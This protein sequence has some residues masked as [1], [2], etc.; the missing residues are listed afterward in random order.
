[1]KYALFSMTKNQITKSI[2]LSMLIFFFL[3]CDKNEVVVYTSV[4]QIFSEPILKE[5]EKKSGIKILALYDVEASKTVGLVNRLIAEKESPKADVFWNSEVSRTIQLKKQGILQPYKSK[6]WD[7]FPRTFKDNEFYWT[8]F[9]ARS[10]ILL[11]NTNLLT[12]DEVP[13]SIFD[14]IKPEWKGKTT[15][16]YPLFG[17]TSTHIAALYVLFGE[18]KVEQYLKNLVANKVVVVDG[19]SVTRD[20][21]AEGKI[22]IGFTDTDDANVAVQGGKPV[23]V[24]YPDKEDFGTLLIPNTVALVKNCPNP[25][26]GKKLIDYLLSTE[27]ESKLAFSESAQ[28]PLRSGVEKPNTIPDISDIRTMNVDYDEI[29]KNVEKAAKFCQKL[30]VR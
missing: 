13:A 11:Y 28:M 3:G 16:A 12:K 19:N 7:V 10:R 15:I 6:H 23:G 25:E 24:I 17:T 5:I 29:S 22:P 30:F 2:K 14:L 20:M 26:N 8:G 9:G 1:M 21:V 27:T 4:D 18:T